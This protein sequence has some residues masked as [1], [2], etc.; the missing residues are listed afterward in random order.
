MIE[1]GGIQIAY[2][3]EDLLGFLLRL[4]QL[5]LQRCKGS[6]NLVGRLILRDSFSSCLKFIV[7]V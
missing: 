4:C 2:R 3:I 5:L 7:A 1:K 6:L